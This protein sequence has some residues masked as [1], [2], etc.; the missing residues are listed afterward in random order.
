MPL[1][2]LVFKRSPLIPQAVIDFL[3]SNGTIKGFDENLDPIFIFNS[4]KV[5]LIYRNTYIYEWFSCD[6][7]GKLKSYNQWCQNGDIVESTEYGKYDWFPYNKDTGL[8]K[9]YTKYYQSGDI[10]E[11]MVYGNTDLI[12]IE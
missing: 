12:T 2:L 3:V 7:D 5:R 8:I 1:M 11:G 9:S 10:G 6:K 4:T